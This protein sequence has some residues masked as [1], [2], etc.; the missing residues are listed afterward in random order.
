MLNKVLI[1]LG[2][3][4]G[5]VVVFVVVV[6]MQPAEFRI[7]RSAKMKVPPAEVFAQVNDFHKWEAWSP[8][9]KLDPNATTKFEG[10]PAGKGAKFS[11][12]GNDKVGAGRQTI[13]E[14]RPD[15]LVQIKL[16]FERPFKDV[17]TAEFNFKPDGEQTNVTWSMYGTRNFMGKAFGLFIDCDKMVGGDFEKG[18]ASMKAIVETPAT[19]TA[20]ASTEPEKKAEN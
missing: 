13:L 14:S 6:A 3:L 4:A 11:W 18:L 17:C 10:E 1:G 12:S 20:V 19:T 16:E 8:W 7:S 5:L 15:E 9:A 2:I